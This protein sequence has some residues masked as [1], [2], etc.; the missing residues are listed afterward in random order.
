MLYMFC[1]SL[2]EKAEKKES[3]DEELF[4]EVS[5]NFKCR[6]LKGA[7]HV[8]AVPSSLIAVKQG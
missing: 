4:L 3:I 1:Y 8:I 6:T 7:F 5:D 2:H